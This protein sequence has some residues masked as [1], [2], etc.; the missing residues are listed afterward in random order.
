M[1]S[2]FGDVSRFAVRYGGKIVVESWRERE[3][4][5]NGALYNG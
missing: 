3:R 1:S 2:V 5:R 4:D